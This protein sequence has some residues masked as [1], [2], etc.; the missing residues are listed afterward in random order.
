MHL[1]RLHDQVFVTH[2]LQMF[3]ESTVSG[4]ADKKSVFNF[5]PHVVKKV[6]GIFPLQ[7]QPVWSDNLYRLLAV[8]FQTS[9]E[10]SFALL[11][12]I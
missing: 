9:Y 8:P 2:I 5:S 1:S 10:I 11:P 4:P 3:N 12:Q 6:S 7:M